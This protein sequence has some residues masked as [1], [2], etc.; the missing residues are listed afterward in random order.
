MSGWSWSAFFEYLVHPLIIYGAWT[1]IWLTAASVAIGLIIGLII[2]FLL[3][4]KNPVFHGIGKFYIWV[5]RGT[6]LLAQLVIIYTALPLFG[7]K[8]SVVVSALIG[9]GM[10]EGAFLAEIVR[11]G[12]MSISKGQT[13]AARGLGMTT[14]MLMRLIVIPQ[15][16]R[17]IV[18]AVGNRINGMLK[19]S[20]LASVI[21][22]EELLRQSQMLTQE[23]F[24]VLELY[25]VA[26]VYYLAMTTIWGRFQGR[27]E[28]FSG[29]AYAEARLSA[30]A[31]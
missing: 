11:A 25:L 16:F 23:K 3:L 24:A 4:S 31:R 8:L 22:M 29:R 9:L 20:S 27:I 7:I 30:D 10:N 28:A 6:P 5:W 17:F 13:E 21:S 1:T 14:P 26:T 2:A 18:P 15:A 12:I 19:M